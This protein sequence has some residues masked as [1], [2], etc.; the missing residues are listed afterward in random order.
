ME[1]KMPRKKTVKYVPCRC[2]ADGQIRM[3][4]GHIRM[5]Y[6]GETDIFVNGAEIPEYM[7]EMDAITVKARKGDG[8]VDYEIATKDMLEKTDFDLQELINHMKQRFDSELDIHP[9]SGKAK[10][11]DLLMDY[12]AKELS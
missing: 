12:R 6:R 2:L 11:I 8:S 1:K 4:N 3:R 9:D 7:E 5:C 10:V